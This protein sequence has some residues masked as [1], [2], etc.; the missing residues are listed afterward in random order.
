M[1]AGQCSGKSNLATAV[2]AIAVAVLSFGAASASPG[3]MAARTACLSASLICC[4]CVGVVS[5]VPAAGHHS[6]LT[7]LFNRTSASCRVPTSTDACA[8]PAPATAEEL[9][10]PMATKR[11]AYP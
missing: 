1:S 11:G 5:S 3:R 9:F 4:C 10:V 7:S 2:I 8:A 6:V